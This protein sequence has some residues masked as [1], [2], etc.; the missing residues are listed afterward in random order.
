MKI[1][2]SGPMTGIPDFNYTAFN[3]AAEKLRS[4]GHEV[5]NPA[6]NPMCDTWAAYMRLSIAQM[7][8]CDQVVML[9][10]WGSSRG[11]CIEVDL[12]AALDIPCAMIDVILGRHKK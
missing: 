4:I 9:P 11:A 7:L 6:D 10:G 3:A 12:A 5:E 2:I 1:F 8:R